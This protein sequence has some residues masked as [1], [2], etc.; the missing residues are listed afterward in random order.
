MR[1]EEAAF[2]GSGD[3]EH[4]GGGTVIRAEAAVFLE[5]AAKFRIGGKENAVGEVVSAEILEE[6]GDGTGKFGSVFGWVMLAW[7]LAIGAIA[8]PRIVAHPEIFAALGP[9]HAFT[10][11]IGHGVKGFLLLGSIVLCVTGCE[12][13]MGGSPENV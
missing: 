5:P 2:G 13:G 8:I 11:L 1:A 7:F 3:D 12:A 4:L 9:H 10:F 6:G